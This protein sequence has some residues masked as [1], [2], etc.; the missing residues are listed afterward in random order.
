MDYNFQDPQQTPENTTPKAE[1]A[2]V[3]NA[4]PQQKVY[5]APQQQTTY[6]AQKKQQT[7]RAR[8]GVG[9]VALA[10]AICMLFSFGAAFG[11]TY[12]ASTMLSA[13]G[14]P[15]VPPSQGSNSNPSIIVQSFENPNKAPGTYDQVAETVSPT[16]VEITTES[17]VT[18]SYIWGGNYVTSGAGS[19]VIISSDGMIVT[20]NHVVSGANTIKVTTKDGTSYTAKVLGTDA[21]TDIAVI[22]I[23]ATDLPF[24]LIGNSD[25]LS[26]GEEVIAVG[27]PLGNL[28]G[29]VTNGIISALSR[30]VMIDGVSMTL[31]QTN[32]E[33]NPGNSGGGLFNMYGELIGIVNAKST[34][35][36]SGV[37]VEGIGF[38]IPITS[39]STVVSELVNYGYVRGR[40][41]IGI[42]YVDIKDSWDAMRYGVSALGIYVTGSIHDAFEVGDRIVAIDGTEITY[43]SDIKAAIR[44]R[45]VGDTVIVKVVRA[46]KYADI[47]ITLTEY[48]PAG[49]AEKDTT[50]EETFENNF[51]Q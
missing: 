1:E 4:E 7:P 49:V 29:T 10:V 41:M 33:V 38:A 34:T 2:P 28:G 51:E 22:K 19:G 12:L 5:I 3:Q 31:I 13:S 16:V 50:D 44:D 39:A 20:N 45:K 14:N 43:S 30:E 8:L 48:V 9:S 26:V 32:A 6:T 15:I 47:T 35:S 23:D 42:N 11:G 24:A 27:N 25:E 40:V 36:S 18:D 21:D 46:G 37:S 17:I